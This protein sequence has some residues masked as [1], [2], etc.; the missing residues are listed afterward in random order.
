M[1]NENLKNVKQ[2]NVRFKSVYT[3]ESLIYKVRLLVI[4][5]NLIAYEIGSK[6]TKKIFINKNTRKEH[7]LFSEKYSLMINF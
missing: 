4:I 3:S 7:S 1:K 6:Y 5:K 2:T